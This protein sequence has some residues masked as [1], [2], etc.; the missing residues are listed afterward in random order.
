MEHE[1]LIVKR[2]ML[3]GT[4]TRMQ[5]TCLVWEIIYKFI[6][7]VLKFHCLRLQATTETITTPALP[8]PPPS[9]LRNNSNKLTIIELRQNNT[10]L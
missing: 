9:L 10:E 4:Q 6:S 5:I 1:A 3:Q 2:V 7:R 8:S